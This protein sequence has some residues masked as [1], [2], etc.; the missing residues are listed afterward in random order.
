M[1]GFSVPKNFEPLMY[2]IERIPYHSIKDLQAF[3][4]PWLSYLNELLFT[5]AISIVL[6]TGC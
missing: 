3:L 6:F 2:K 5:G 4:N 1:T